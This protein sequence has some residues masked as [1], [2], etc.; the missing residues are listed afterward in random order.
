MLSLAEL[1]AIKASLIALAGPNTNAIA[2]HVEALTWAIQTEQELEAMRK[3]GAFRCPKRAKAV[4][5]Q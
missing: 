3:A 4:S 1:M 2:D 5:R